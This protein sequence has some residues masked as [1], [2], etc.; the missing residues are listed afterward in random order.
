MSKIKIILLLVLLSL[1]M[2]LSTK[3]AEYSHLHLV[4]YANPT[5]LNEIKRRYEAYDLTDGNLTRKIQFNTEYNEETCSI[6]SYD[7]EVT[8][9]NSLGGTTT[10]HD[11]ILVRDFISPTISSNVKEII[12]DTSK[13]FDLNSIYQYLIIEDNLDTVF[14]NIIIEGLEAIFDEVGY[15]SL[16]CYVIDS[17]TNKSNVIELNILAIKTITEHLITSS[18]NVN[19]NSLSKEEIIKLFIENF[20]VPNGYNEIK[21]ISN[22][23]EATDDGIYPATIHFIFADGTSEQYTFKIELKNAQNNTNYLQVYWFTGAAIFLI[24]I[25]VIIYR[26][27]R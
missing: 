4:N 21:I 11:I 2:P 8:I 1:L 24:I 26:K 22:Y 15:Y 3:A 25:G 18:L 19:T 9:T 6:G 16:K 17:S 12:I 23:F 5:P 14:D 27:R 13:E 7:L 20:E 10:K